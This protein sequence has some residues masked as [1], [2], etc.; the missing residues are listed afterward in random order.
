[1]MVANSCAAQFVGN[2]VQCNARSGYVK[3]VTTYC[4]LA[5]YELAKPHFFI[6]AIERLVTAEPV[7]VLRLALFALADV[8]MA[9]RLCSLISASTRE[10]TISVQ[11]DT[12]SEAAVQ[13]LMKCATDRGVTQA[14][15]FFNGLQVGGINSFHPKLVYIE[16]TSRRLSFVGTGNISHGRKH[17]DYVVPAAVTKETTDTTSVQ[18]LVLWTECVTRGINSETFDNRRES[19][20]QIRETCNNF[21]RQEAFF[22]L[23][24][25]TRQ[26]L[27]RMGYLAASAT[28]VRLVSQGFNSQDINF[29]SRMTLRAGKRVKIL[30]DDDIYWT[31]IY[32]L[33]DL[34]NEPYEYR[35]FLL[36]LIA[37]G[38]EVRYVVTNHHAVSRNFQHAKGYSFHRSAGGGSAILGSAN[39]T[40]AALS[41]NLEILV[42]VDGADFDRYS[43]WFEALWERSIPHEAMPS[44]DPMAK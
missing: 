41:D 6:S 40:S 16:T 3:P 35:E 32:P 21:D 34:M 9:N 18:S 5:E 44:A 22:L 13:H 25:D 43:S 31:S 23:P 19:V 28:E 14:K 38:A 24:G 4:S 2:D 12:S 20:L 33:N 30:L 39:A 8:S 7:Q 29:L 11:K 17:L 26:L 42:E 15:A 37:L 1:M 27:V 10:V 36:P